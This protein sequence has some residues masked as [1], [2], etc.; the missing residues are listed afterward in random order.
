MTAQRFVSMLVTVTALILAMTQATNLRNA[1]DFSTYQVQS[2]MD[3]DS[4][5]DVTQDSTPSIPKPPRRHPSAGSV[6]E[7]QSRVEDASAP[8]DA[9]GVKAWAQCGGLYYLGETR[10]Q[11]HTFCKQLS[12]FISVCFPESRP[13]EKVVRLEL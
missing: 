4:S 2:Q 8:T 7:M 9:D 13:T 1:G 6:I 5:V 12:D 11:Q 3:A 10:C